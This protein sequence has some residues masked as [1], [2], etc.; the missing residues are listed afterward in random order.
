MIPKRYPSLSQGR[1]TGRTCQKLD[2]EV[3]FEPGEPP[4][5]DRLGDAKPARGGRN[6]SG[7][8]DLDECP[9]LFS[10]KASFVD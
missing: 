2:A 3:H 9:E 7:I 8:G 10:R 5:D 6:A 1:A 4:A